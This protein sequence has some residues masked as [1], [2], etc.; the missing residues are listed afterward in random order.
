MAEDTARTR[1]GVL[2]T[3]RED[4]TGSFFCDRIAVGPKP[5]VAMHIWTVVLLIRS[6]AS[7][8]AAAGGQ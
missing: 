8:Q 4:A 7:L 3:A 5:V 2:K 6:K 1:P